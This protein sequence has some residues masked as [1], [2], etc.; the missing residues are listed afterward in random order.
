MNI[1]LHIHAYPPKH[2]CG[3]EYFAHR[4]NKY[5]VE[6][7]HIVKVM[8]GERPGDK[9][10]YTIDG[11]EVFGKPSN[12]G[13]M[14]NWADVVITHL[15]YTRDTIKMVQFKPVVWYMHNT[16]DYP[17]VRSNPRVHVIYNSE[18]ARQ[19]I[20]Y[21]NPSTLTFPP[22]VDMPNV[23]KTPEKNT[24]VTLINLNESKGGKV[25]AEIARRMPDIQFMGVIGSYG[26]QN[27][28]YPSNVVI[29]PNTPNIQEV[30]N[31]T[32]ILIM[33]S[34]Y[35]S[36]GM[37]ATEAMQNGIPVIA[38]PTF[39]LKENLGGSGIFVDRKNIDGWVEAI[40]N[41]QGKKEYTAASKAARKR[42]DE[43]RP[44]KKLEEFEVF[45]HKIADKP[46]PQKKEYE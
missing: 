40:N 16:F 17:T 9:E 37:T 46:L 28:E 18:A 31:K 44:Q 36:W 32:K 3:A 13:G 20:R 5:L 23:C 22:P 19:E 39:G 10:E 12:W 24:Y 8:L 11:V 25:L 30:Y 27:L 43:L 4:I 2:N 45:L 33:P 1:L 42:G 14:F 7:G 26:A 29:H 34:D 21:P 15:D 35:E 41:L 38:N 6:Q